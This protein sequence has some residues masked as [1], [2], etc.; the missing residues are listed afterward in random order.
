MIGASCQEVPY[1]KYSRHNCFEVRVERVLCCGIMGIMLLMWCDMRYTP[2]VLLPHTD[3][4]YVMMAASPE[5]RSDWVQAF[6]QH[7]LS[8]RKLR[9]AHSNLNVSTD[10]SSAASRDGKAGADGA[11]E[12][13]ISGGG[14]PGVLAHITHA[15][16]KPAGPFGGQAYTEYNIVV[17][18][19]KLSWS[20]QKRYTQFKALHRI[21]FP[22]YNYLFL[23]DAAPF[24]PPEFPPKTYAV[25]SSLDRAVVESRIV[26]FDRYLKTLLAVPE[27]AAGVELME[28]LG[29]IKV[30]ASSAVSMGDQIQRAQ[31]AETRRRR[32]AQRHAHAAASGGRAK[33][34]PPAG[35]ARRRAHSVHH[36]N[37]MGFCDIG[38][39]L[40]M[41]SNTTF[42]SVTRTIT[43]SEWD[44]VGIITREPMFSKKPQSLCVL[45]AVNSGV[46]LTPLEGRLISSQSANQAVAIR[47]LRWTSHP[48][49]LQAL[50][51]FQEVKASLCRFPNR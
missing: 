46:L 30:S 28:F 34:P 2:Q 11:P 50:L 6:N 26:L 44:H 24:P 1:D 3:R 13:P 45:E 41:R 32:S 8:M 51:E 36:E 29:L 17:R 15:R 25:K 23:T 40:L 38:D 35:A 37:I 12:K 5:E 48:E 39:I 10:A 20:V 33:S 18:S 21:L 14:I 4:R 9:S 16:N 42:S 31:S 7:T 49:A 43:R 27:L 22:R 19:G 47:K